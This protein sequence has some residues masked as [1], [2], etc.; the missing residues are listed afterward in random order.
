MH[1]AQHYEGGTRKSWT[2]LCFVSK[3]IKIIV[4][5][6][7]Y[8]F[9][10]NIKVMTWNFTSKGFMCLRPICTY[11]HSAIVSQS[12][13][14]CLMT[15]P[16]QIWFTVGSMPDFVSN[17][18]YLIT[19]ALVKGILISSKK[20]FPARYY[21]LSWPVFIAITILTWLIDWFM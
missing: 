19:S 6:Y 13:L 1:I 18:I 15:L 14:N 2:C 9:F 21:F 4:G 12:V 5:R 20:L 16:V 8:I 7:I 10:K 3:A 17:Q 11:K